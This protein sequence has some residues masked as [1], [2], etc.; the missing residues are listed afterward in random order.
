MSMPDCCSLAA[1]EHQYPLVFP[2][3]FIGFVGGGIYR[4]PCLSNQ[5]EI[6]VAFVPPSASHNLQL[7]RNLTNNFI[8]LG[9]LYDAVY[10]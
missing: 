4:Y 9:Y 2:L 8:T 3:I 6:V 5:H 1:K 10:F 7:H